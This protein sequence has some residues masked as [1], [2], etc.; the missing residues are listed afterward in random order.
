M[1]KQKIYQNNQEIEQVFEALEDYIR[2]NHQLCSITDI[3]EITN[4]SRD[5]CDKAL[6]FL[7]K[8]KRVEKIYE[9]RGKPTIIIPKYLLD[10]ILQ[11]Q[12]KPKWM[13][14]YFFAEKTPILEKIANLKEEINRYEIIER[15]LYATDIPLEVSVTFC[16]KLLDFEEVTHHLNK[17]DK[18][19]SFKYKGNKYLVEV[20]GTK[21]QGDKRKITQLR[22]WVDNEVITNNQEIDKIK[23]IFVINHYRNLD[24]D[25]RGDPLTSHSK[26]FLK[27]YNYKFFTTKFLYDIVKQILDNSLSNDE[28]K[29][30]IIDGE[31]FDD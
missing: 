16:L 6:N 10:E 4:L 29:S 9:G 18:D 31:E 13:K 5:K 28:A 12:S 15:L 21:K 1:T 22:G 14:K 23:G 27:L 24:P 2:D 17:G 30:K 26:K 25:D 3:K 8:Q 7:I 20:E 19:V 11:L